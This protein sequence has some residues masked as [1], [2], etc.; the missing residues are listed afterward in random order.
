MHATNTAVIKSRG[1][2]VAA[3]KTE[4][5]TSNGN[6][7]ALYFCAASRLIVD[8]RAV[9]AVPEEY[10]A[11]SVGM[12]MAKRDL[13]QNIA[14]VEDGVHK[15]I[16]SKVSAGIEEIDSPTISQ[17]LKYELLNGVHPRLP[18]LKDNT[19]AIGVVW[20]YRQLQFQSE[21]FRNLQECRASNDSAMYAMKAAYKTVFDNYHG[22][23]L[24]QGFNYAFKGAPPI[25]MIFSMMNPDLSVSI[26][27]KANEADVVILPMTFH[28]TDKDRDDEVVED[29]F[30]GFDLFQN[31]DRGWKTLGGKVEQEWF[32]L[33]DKLVMGGNRPM[34]E[35]RSSVRSSS[36]SETDADESIASDG[37]LSVKTN[38]E[39]YARNS[40]PSFVLSGP[41]LELHIKDETSK[42]ANN[43]MKAYSTV[44]SPMLE[45]ISWTINDFGMNDPSK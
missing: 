36:E 17:L 40:I 11:Y 29:M 42:A 16:D 18:K 34:K 22:W 19:V 13:I 6:Y 2:N 30:H 7:D 32:G 28:S 9:K 4:G 39:E 43:D 37:S 41:S 20:M 23:A 15:W 25:S 31:I 33:I 35:N 26:E 10:K 3:A 14:K 8:W 44:M 27:N 24:Q 38:C 12:K 45:D 1:F 5:T 21:I